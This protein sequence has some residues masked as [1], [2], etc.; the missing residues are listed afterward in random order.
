MEG[1][2]LRGKVACKRQRKTKGE[3]LKKRYSMRVTE[4]Q[5]E[6]LEWPLEEQE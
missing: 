2:A 3:K 4:W 1:A 5:V 6:D